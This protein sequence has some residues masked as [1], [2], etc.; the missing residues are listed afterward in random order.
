MRTQF[1]A[2]TVVEAAKSSK[3]ARNSVVLLE[4]ADLDA[5][6]ACNQINIWLSYGF[7]LQTLYRTLRSFSESAMVNCKVSIRRDLSPAVDL[8]VLV[9]G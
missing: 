4:L 2:V 5:I 1:S 3:F 7:L 8:K 9:D 6:I